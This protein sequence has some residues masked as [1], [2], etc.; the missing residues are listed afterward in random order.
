MKV[1]QAQLFLAF[2]HSSLAP[3]TLYTVVVSPKKVKLSREYFWH[4]IRMEMMW[5][6]EEKG[7]NAEKFGETLTKSFQQEKFHMK[8]RLTSP[9]TDEGIQ[10]WTIV[11]RSVGEL[12]MMII[13]IQNTLLLKLFLFA[14][15]R[16]LYAVQKTF[17]FT[18]RP[19]C[20]LHNLIKSEMSHEISHVVGWL[21]CNSLKLLNTAFMA[22]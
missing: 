22:V 15:N 11:Q 19:N 8:T 14:S 18:F 16:V 2:H 21:N 7:K 6:K 3:S 20:V 13:R 10:R 5:W 12:M 17:H 9:L 1:K 4:E